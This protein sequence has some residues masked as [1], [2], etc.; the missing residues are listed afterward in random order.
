MSKLLNTYKNLKEKDFET[1]YLFKNGAFY[2]A[3]EDDAKLLSNEFEL[4]LTN[5]N[6]NAVKC[7]FPCSSFDKYYLKLKNIDKEFKIV[8][9]NTISDSTIYLQ[10]R[11]IKNLI[12]EIVSIDI[13]NLSVGEAVLF[14]KKKIT[15]KNLN[16]LVSF[17]GMLIYIFYDILLKLYF[18]IRW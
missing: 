13:E 6:A 14:N 5:L 15:N 1:I 18:K 16:L 11:E 17:I 7:G 4:K 9:S 3:L 2:L 8:D 12:N 10:N